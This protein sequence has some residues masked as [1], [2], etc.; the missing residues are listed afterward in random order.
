[1]QVTLTPQAEQL[2]R[3]ALARY[4]E[5]SPEQIVEQALGEH[6][7]TQR[8]FLVP[9]PVGEKL[10]GIPGI[11]LPAHWPPNFPQFDPLLVEGEPVSEQLIRERR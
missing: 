11:K 9:D 2:L 3:E 4:P 5:Q 7:R 10:K 6:F 1:M 8:S